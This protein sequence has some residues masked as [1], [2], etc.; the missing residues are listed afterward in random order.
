MLSDFSEFYCCRVWLGAE[1]LGNMTAEQGGVYSLVI[2]RD[3]TTT[4]RISLTHMLTTPNTVHM[5]WLLPQIIIITI[6]SKLPK[7]WICQH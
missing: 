7:L 1:R 6:V 4:K 5:F 2:T 3:P